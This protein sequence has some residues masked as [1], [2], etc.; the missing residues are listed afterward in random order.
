MS[1]LNPI[2]TLNLSF[3]P[4]QHHSR[5][6]T[7]PSIETHHSDAKD[8]QFVLLL[9]SAVSQAASNTTVALCLDL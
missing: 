4:L 1:Y 7:S 9:P 3:P 2:T 6:N 8:L 5:T